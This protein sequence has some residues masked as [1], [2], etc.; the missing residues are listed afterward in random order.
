MAFSSQFSV[1]NA[2]KVFKRKEDEKAQSHSAVHKKEV[3][4]TDA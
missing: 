3:E 2:E 4:N 1:L